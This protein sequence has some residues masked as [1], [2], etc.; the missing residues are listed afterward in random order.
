LGGLGLYDYVHDVLTWVDV[1]GLARCGPARKGTAWNHIFEGHWYGSPAKLR[2]KNDIFGRLEKHEIMQVV[3]E[4]WRLREKVQ[5][6]VGVN[7]TQIRYLAKVKNR[8]WN[9]V[10]EMW[11]EVETGI[12]KSAY[13]KGTR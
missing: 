4:A 5:T 6:Q 12:L 9:G 2:G 10:I 11:L 1:L 3:D 7:G 13:P 8:L